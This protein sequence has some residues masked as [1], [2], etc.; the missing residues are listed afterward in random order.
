MGIG[1]MERYLRLL[2]TAILALHGLMPAW[3]MQYRDQR[4]DEQRAVKELFAGGK[5]SAE[6][7]F[8]FG[9]WEIPYSLRRLRYFAIPELESVRLRHDESPVT[10]QMVK[11]AQQARKLD[12]GGEKNHS[13]L[14]DFRSQRLEELRVFVGIGDEPP[15]S[16][17]ANCP[18]LKKFQAPT[19]QLSPP[20]LAALLSHPR[21]E[22]LEIEAH[23]ADISQVAPFAGD[24]GLQELVF[25][26]SFRE[27]D[28]L[29]KPPK[30]IPPGFIPVPRVAEIEDKPALGTFIWLKQCPHFRRLNL[31]LCDAYPLCAAIG[32][33]QAG[34]ERLEVRHV[35]V[36]LLAILPSWKRL[37][38]LTV[39][40]QKL[41]SSLLAKANEAC[42]QLHT[43]EIE[44][45]PD[46]GFRLGT[47]WLQSLDKLKNL[48]RLRL[49]GCSVKRAHLAAIVAAVPQLEAI[50]LE[51]KG[52][53]DAD[54]E[55][56]LKLAH[57][58]QVSFERTSAKHAKRTFSAVHRDWEDR[59]WRAYL[60]EDDFE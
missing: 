11:A 6:Y 44:E 55:P 24:S 41:D 36:K 13:I 57:L 39:D 42:P 60:G 28:W 23:M 53:R 2:R 5:S 8:Y 40:G 51:D 4:V 38:H 59:P 43:L 54:L 56:L 35:T 14:K 34:I 19:V 9:N 21:L 12:Y 1:R 37:R 52:L 50:S 58:K 22:V 29:K 46:G 15:L 33:H 18:Q 16:F 7:G 45:D 32:K 31:S 20:S 25:R 17:V 27:S 30:V 47:D 49:G 10:P 3:L 26:E 48:K